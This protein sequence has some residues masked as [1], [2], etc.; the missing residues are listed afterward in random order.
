MMSGA[1]PGAYDGEWSGGPPPRQRSLLSGLI[2]AGAC[3]VGCA[4]QQ[5]VPS[6]PVPTSPPPSAPVAPADA[7]APRPAVEPTAEG[8]SG[9]A[10]AL[11]P[12][13]GTP[14]SDP[15]VL[16]RRIL[17]VKIDNAPLAR[18][19][20]GLRA[21]DVVYEQLAEGGTTRFLAMYLA[22]DPERV[23]PVRSA[24]LT[25][26]YL[27]QEWDF[28]LAYAGAGTTTARLLAEA[29]IPLFKAPELSE[30]LEGTPYVRDSRR[31][32]PHNLFLRPAQLRRAAEAE[33][34]IAPV[35]EIR[36][37][38]FADPPAQPGP[39]RSVSVPYA[40]PGPANL[41][42]AVNW[43]YDPGSS[44][45]KRTMAGAP[46]VDGLDGNQIEAENVLVQYA[47]IFTALNVEP[48]SAGNAVL[49]TVLRGEHPL[50]L[51]HSGQL[52]EGTWTKAHN[53]AKT[54]YSAA[55]GGPLLFRP[56][57]VWIHIVPSDFRVTWT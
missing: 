33:P 56:G 37:F 4:S 53:R 14:V 49:D 44:T 7:L 39:V 30:P 18:P 12:L 20:F 36:P 26:I 29:L 42:F 34:G 10:P 43:R 48:D 40:P 24:R 52:F 1:G 16:R 3:V 5:A 35:V 21:A 57:R 22:Q 51:F 54:E 17:A 15:A 41:Q 23:G 27:G 9:A 19:Q 45:W 13:T 11:S 55:D 6:T 47:Q 2:A 28:L 46:H 8:T 38:P 32:V 25:D 50:R 31:P